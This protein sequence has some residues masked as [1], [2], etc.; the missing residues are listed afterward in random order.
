[1]RPEIDKELEAIV[2]TAMH[3][4]QD[5]RY[6]TAREFF[7]ALEEHNARQPILRT[8]QQRPS[9]PTPA[10]QPP[11]VRVNPTPATPIMPQ[12]AVQHWLL[13]NVKPEVNE[14]FA[15]QGEVMVGRDR[16]CSI[17]LSHPAV[18]RKH[19]K[20]TASGTQLLLEDLKSANGTYVNN[21]RIERAQ[22]KP[23]DVV[24]FGA[25]PACSYVLRE[26]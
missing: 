14:K 25:D 7:E 24:R 16:T 21:A 15:L 8:A 17:V 1:V 18:S 9:G 22:L 11:T 12:P 19:A 3:P 23:G 13:V 10:P 26:H 2:M 4:R 5:Q 6:E 20:I